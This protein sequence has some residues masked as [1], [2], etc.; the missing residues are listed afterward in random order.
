MRKMKI[1]IRIHVGEMIWIENGDLMR[2][3]LEGRNLKVFM[4]NYNKK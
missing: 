3:L 4:K 2:K 1:F